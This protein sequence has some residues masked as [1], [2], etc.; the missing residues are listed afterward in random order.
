MPVPMWVAQVNKR[1]F[2]PRELRKGV[3]PVLTHVGRS[4]GTTYRTPLDA[5]N[6]EGGYIF[7]VMYGSASDWVQNVLAAGSATLK[8]DSDELELV[9][10]RLVSKEDAWQLLPSTTKAPANFLRVTEYLQMDVSG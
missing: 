6:V 7:I 2:N 1:V 8:V 9:S 4:S 10:P 3:R 5:H